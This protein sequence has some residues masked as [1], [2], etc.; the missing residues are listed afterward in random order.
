MAFLNATHKRRARRN[1][2][3][4]SREKKSGVFPRW[5][6][7]DWAGMRFGIVGAVFALAWGV[8][9]VRAGYVQLWEGPYLAERARRQHLSAEMVSAPRGMIMDRNGVVLARS[10]ECRSVY[11]NPQEIDDVEHTARVLAAILH[12]PEEAVRTALERGGRFAWLARRVDDAMAEEVRQA[13]LSGIELARE[14]ERMYPFKQVAGQLLGFVGVDGKGL[15]GIERAY[16]DKLSGLASRRVVQ[17][18]ATG[19]RFYVN[20]DDQPAVA[21]NLH[22]TLDLQIQFIAEEVLAKAV[23]AVEA[24]WGG[25]LVADVQSGDIL[26]WAQYPF[27]NPNSFREYKPS[28]YRNRLALDALEPGSTFKP[29]LIASALQEGVITRDTVFNCENGRWKSR[30]ITIRDDGRAYQELPVHRILS[31][32]SNI[33]CAKIGLELGTAKYYR[34]LT[35]L[36]FG[37]RIGLDVAESKGI[38]RTPRDWSEADL[39]SA[40]FGQSISVTCAQMAQGYMTLANQGRH[41][42]LRLVLDGESADVEQRVFSPSVAREV[43]RMMH[44]VVADGTGT[45]A[46]IPGVDVAGKTG[47]AQKADK[48]GTYGAKRTASFVGMLPADNPAYLIVIMLD[49]PSKSVYGGAIAAPVFREVAA[50]MLAYKGELPDAG[51]VAEGK[52]PKKTRQAVKVESR[53]RD[54][55]AGELRRPLSA[56]PPKAEAMGVVPDVVG[57]SVRRAVELFAQQGLVPVIRGEGARVVRQSPPAGVSFKNGNT[58]KDPATECVLW[59][60]E[61]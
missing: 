36:G 3:R 11:A 7:L 54:A 18:D 38:V 1:I 25:V 56:T 30:L 58:G 52:T 6:R 48:S 10:V 31:V 21:E 49:E 13:G 60:S 26:A 45:R 39:I 22:L 20:S 61:K 5:A 42:P 14:Y 28:V 23:D 50:R 17:R 43:I 29:F 55:T 4:A 32:S 27:F 2:A 47:T 34:Y 51:A 53:S 35:R 37:R 19:R 46:A 8:L 33:G 12:E 24:N 9:W 57:K 16:D 41:K 44:E 40:S 59:L 15:E